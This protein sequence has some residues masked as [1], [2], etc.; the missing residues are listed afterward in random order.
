MKVLHIKHVFLNKLN[1]VVI[2]ILIAKK[3]VFVSR[4][5]L[6]QKRLHL[7]LLF[8]VKKWVALISR[9]EIINLSLSF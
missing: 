5:H 1:V 7:F 6:L 2:F 4:G 9:S 8:F 3:A